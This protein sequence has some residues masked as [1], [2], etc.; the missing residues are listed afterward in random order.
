MA[1]LLK[2]SLSTGYGVT[3]LLRKLSLCGGIVVID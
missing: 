1:L 3:R 2:L